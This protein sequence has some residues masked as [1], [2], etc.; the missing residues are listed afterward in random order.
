[1]TKAPSDHKRL[2]WSKPEVRRIAAGS[3]ENTLKTG[4]SD[5]GTDVNGKNFS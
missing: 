2:P 1:M 4:T 3:A 5:G